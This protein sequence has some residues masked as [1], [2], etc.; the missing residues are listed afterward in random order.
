MRPK[1]VLTI[2]LAA[3]GVAIIAVTFKNLRSRPDLPKPVI[4]A[5]TSNVT[6]SNP[7]ASIAPTSAVP[8]P[9]TV[10][11]NKTTNSEAE[12]EEY[13]A[14]RTA[15]LNSLA[16]QKSPA[17]HQQIID[18]L[19]NSD[20]EIR[21]A[22]LE[23]IQQ[24]NDRSVIPQMKQIADETDDAQEKQDILDAIDFINLPSLTEY[25]QQSHK[26]KK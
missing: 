11:I 14:K 20:K 10:S 7:I 8:A 9:T 18:E 4:A 19:K 1:I 12:H 25:L 6:K 17:A 2:L 23:A 15:Q 13:V 21:K 22:S 3:I 24:A 5:T 26:A 16:M